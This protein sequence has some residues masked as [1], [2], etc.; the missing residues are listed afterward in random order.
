MT[1]DELDRLAAEKIMG[2]IM[3]LGSAYAKDS[4]G[5]P[6]QEMHEIW[7]PT[8]N[9]AQAWECLEKLKRLGPAVSYS[10]DTSDW[11]C[12]FRYSDLE[13]NDW[14]SRSAP[15]AIVRACLKAKGVIE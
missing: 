12:Q 11:E 5:N 1:L 15:E 3:D 4:D 9:I 2:W 6:A 14:E 10:C 7:Q 13:I 8:R